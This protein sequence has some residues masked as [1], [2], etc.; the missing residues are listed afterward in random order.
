L[1]EVKELLLG[2]VVEDAPPPLKLSG[3]LGGFNL[4][5]GSKQRGGGQCVQL[6]G[7]RAKIEKD[8]NKD[9]I[10]GSREDGGGRTILDPH[11]DQ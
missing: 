6:E 2:F 3:R 4:R 9:P 11:V 5:A 8:K 7:D 1:V 10:K